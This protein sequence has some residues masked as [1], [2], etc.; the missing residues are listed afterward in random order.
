MVSVQE[1]LISITVKEG[2]T[3]PGENNE[4]EL[5]L[6][7]SVTPD[8]AINQ[9]LTETTFADA[10]QRDLDG[11]NIYLHSIGETAL[12]T[13]EEEKNLARRIQRFA[14][15]VAW[16]ELICA[17]LR[18]VFS[19]AKRYRG[20]GADFEDLIQAGNLG[21]IRAVEKFDPEK[22]YKFSTYAYWWIRQAIGREAIP[23]SRTIYTPAHVETK[24]NRLQKAERALANK[25]GRTP[26][27]EEIAQKSG[28][29]FNQAL[30]IWRVMEPL[31]SLNT[32]IGEEE[33]S[34]LGDL[35]EQETFPNPEEEA[36]RNWFKEMI[37][38][39][40]E[41]SPLLNPRERQVLKLRFGLMGEDDQFRTLEEVGEW[42][43][44]RISK[45]RVRQIE[46]GALE[47]LRESE[48][49]RQLLGV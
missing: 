22:D 13:K 36:E 16:E 26:T 9:L 34:E 37:K 29:S 30:T 11:L 25:F 21:L 2:K 14:D 47:K 44:P 17:N 19:V 43:N 4:G 39:F 8:G 45:E 7:A 35:L 15:R 38:D 23:L 5:D 27:L 40:I 31:A 12:L 20:R 28:I 48:E 41:N 42:F 24:R 32:L 6:L 1:R 18:L 46:A 3:L 33:T 10:D 49:L